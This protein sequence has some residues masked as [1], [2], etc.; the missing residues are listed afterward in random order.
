M[1]EIECVPELPVYGQFDQRYSAGATLGVGGVGEVTLYADRFIGRAVALKTMRVSEGES[2]GS[3]TER[4]LREARVQG[5]LE[6][7]SIVPVYDCGVRPDGREYFTMM[8]VRGATLTD[9]LRARGEVRVD[10]DRVGPYGRRRLLEAFVR[11]CL[12]VDFAHTRGIVHRDLKPSNIMLGD[13]GEVYVLDWGVAKVLGSPE[14]DAGLPEPAGVKGP[15][16]TEQ[17]KWLGT[18]G[19]MAPEQLEAGPVDARTDVYALGAI[20]FEILAGRPLHGPGNPAEIVRSTLSGADARPSQRCPEVELPPE[21]DAISQRATARRPEDR[22]P[23]ARALSEDVE[24]FLDGDR[25]LMLRRGLAE[26][27][28]EAARSALGQAES[29][30]ESSEAVRSQALRNAG[31]ALALDPENPA[32]L[33]VLGRLMLTEPPSEPEEVRAA[34]RQS[35]AALRLRTVRSLFYRSLSWVAVVP[36]ALWIGYVSPKAAALIIGLV[37]G[38]SLLTAG[39]C[40]L[41]AV[42]IRTGFGLLLLT[43]AL[44]AVLSGLY[45]PFMLVPTLIATNTIFFVLHSNPGQRRLIVALGVLATVLPFLGELAGLIPP[46]CEFLDGRII[47]LPRTLAFPATGTKVLLLVTHVM[48]VIAPALFAAAVRDSLLAAQRKLFLHTWQVSQIA[49]DL[50]A[51]DRASLSGVVP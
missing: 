35:A 6:H 31:Q 39:A 33:E 37:L 32:A 16:V 19:F 7:P 25:D 30:P 1:Q 50:R 36:L 10:S 18:P 44:F 24:K 34:I 51:G 17:G 29:S 38:T 47:L 12:A 21:F 14:R 28:A 40:R 4:F 46:S 23:T 22:Y 5:Q 27:H 43:T 41:R 48:M 11:V 49:A 8:R 9:V 2:T 26:R 45:G 42:S 3:T 20:L 15:G 13:F